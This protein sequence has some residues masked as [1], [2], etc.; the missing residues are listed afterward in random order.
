M[1]ENYSGWKILYR[2]H[3]IRRMQKRRISRREVNAVVRH[4][5]EIED[6]PENLPFRASCYVASLMEGQYM[7]P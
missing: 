6:N 7:S 4:G 3:A 1:A 5:V 2:D